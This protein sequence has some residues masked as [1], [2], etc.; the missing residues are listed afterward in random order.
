MAGEATTTTTA[1]DIYFA[2]WVGDSILDEARPHMP[3]KPLMNFEGRKPTKAFDFPVQ[4]DPG[5]GAAWT[6]GADQASVQTATSLATSKATAT[7]QM[8]G[9][10]AI[11]TDF[12]DAISVIDAVAHFS[13]VLGRSC[14]EE[15]EVITAA[16]YANFSQAT[17]STTVLL[18]DDFNKAIGGLEARDAV[19]SLVAVLSAKQLSDLR[20]DLTGTVAASF[21]GSEKGA[22][23]VGNIADANLEGKAE[24]A[25]V[26]IYTTTAVATGGGDDKGG[27]FVKGVSNGFYEVWDSRPEQHREALRP[28]T[29]LVCSVNF[30]V[31][32]IRDAWGQGL[33][34]DS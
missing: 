19:G 22:A 32:E 28:G 1:N 9:Q 5:A 33:F 8:Y 20:R 13:R 25:G 11:V 26:D 18:L 3:S 29:Q 17:T 10:A 31:A 15:V 21:Y 4:D 27:V 2:A 24:I 14:G 7:A 23:T 12:I 30:G 6:E 16:Q 34:S